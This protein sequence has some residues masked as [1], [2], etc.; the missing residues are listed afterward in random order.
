MEIIFY[1]N[2]RVSFMGVYKNIRLVIKLIKYEIYLF[3]INIKTSHFLILGTPFIFQSDLN[4]GTEEDTGRQFGTVKD[5]DYRLIAKFY[6]GPSN[7]AGRRRVK[8]GVF[9][10]L[11]L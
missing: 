1:S 10:S 7:N 5:I 6:T 3:V 9:S 11:N 4:L 8:A 2:Y